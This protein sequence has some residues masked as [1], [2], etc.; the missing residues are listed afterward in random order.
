MGSAYV[1]LRSDAT[2]PTSFEDALVHRLSGPT[3]EGPAMVDMVL[4]RA[5]EATACHSALMTDE[6]AAE[7][8]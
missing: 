4:A 7:R 3:A 2:R 5:T 8:V 1:P 6:S